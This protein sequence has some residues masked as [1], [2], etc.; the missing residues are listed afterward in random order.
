MTWK[1]YQLFLNIVATVIVAIVVIGV[2]II[3]Y[4]YLK[5]PDTKTQTIKIEYHISKSKN[6]ESNKAEIK[7]LDSILKSITQTSNKI[8]QKQLELI[9]EKSDENFFNKLYTAIVAIILAIAGFF[10]FKSISEIKSQ[11]IDDAKKESTKIAKKIAK[12]EAKEEFIR[13]FNPEYEANVFAQ[14]NLAMN[15]LLRTEIQSLNERVYALEQNGDNPDDNI[16]DNDNPDGDGP[17]E[18]QTL[19]TLNN[20]NNNLATDINLVEPENPF[21]NE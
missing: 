3:S 13:T 14:A 2:L 10:G 12:K 18:N 4:N 16:I 15:E 20:E 1:K 6:E 8:Q 11:A 21:E 17:D 5:I 9:D 7:K 19:E